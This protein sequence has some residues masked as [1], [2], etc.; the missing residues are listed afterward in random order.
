MY[1]SNCGKEIDDKAVICI[2]CGCATQ[3]S[4]QKPTKSMALALV[5]WF[6]LGVF[7]AHRFYLG[8]NQSGSVILFLWIFG[9]ITVWFV[10]GLIPL[11]IVG[12]WWFV[13]LFLILC[14]N[15]K[16]ADGSELV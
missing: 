14:K 3:N 16:P 8:D 12:I 13:D 1:C 4:I 15:I 7:G 11:I 6:F 5:L 2:H 9:W 10:V